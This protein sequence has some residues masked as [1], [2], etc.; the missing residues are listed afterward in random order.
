VSAL[1]SVWLE[2]QLGLLGLCALGWLL[3]RARLEPGT[4]VRAV[5]GWLLLVPLVV[6]LP[7]L[8]PDPWRP[9]SVMAAAAA[10]TRA[11]ARP[12]LAPG[13]RHVPA[14][15]S[16]PSPWLLLPL[17]GLA[18]GARALRSAHQLRRHLRATTLV[19]RLGRVEIRVC[20]HGP[21]FA[22]QWGRRA[23]IVLDRATWREP[24]SRDL[25]LRHELVH[26]RHRDP[27]WAWAWWALE[28]A[29]LPLP[30]LR[31]LRSRSTALEELACDAAV[32]RHVPRER[33][34]RLLLQAARPPS[35][36][37]LAPA[38]SAPPLR[39]R[40][41]MLIEPRTRRLPLAVL[42]ALGM[43]AQ[44][45]IA[46]P[47]R[48][49]TLPLEQLAAESSEPGFAIA[50]HPLVQEQLEHIMASDRGWRH[51]ASGLERRPQHA[52]LVDTALAEAGLPAALAAVPL[53]ESGYDNLPEAKARSA[54]PPGPMGAGLWMFIPSTARQ[55]GLLVDERTDE[56][57]DVAR[58][59]EAAVALLSDL[60]AEFG[61]WGLALA[62]YN[63]GAEHVRAAIA[64]TGTTDP[65]ALMEQ[66]AINDY[67]A[68][69]LAAAIVLDHP[70]L[71][72][73][74]R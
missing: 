68:R 33:Y 17:L 34:A 38:L 44:L 35:P 46:A 66:G 73:G 47:P 36:A 11:L 21:C 62:G 26:H 67:V 22:A 51:F 60:Y 9:P 56:R 64:E 12:P 69:V 71:V 59:T 70:E 2:V 54:A 24:E 48:A 16:L 55:Y 14:G 42:L 18:S 7:R 49:Q 57:L 32:V 19:R 13:E 40:L 52:S 27:Q 72:S 61:D 31:A 39:E 41:H 65:L 1:S 53:V 63:Q 30:P 15:R 58:E 20:A 3:D 45:A 29:L 23:V 74:S 28:A 5:R 25:A 37:E 6:L 43:A 8:A 4:W 10:Q 50:P